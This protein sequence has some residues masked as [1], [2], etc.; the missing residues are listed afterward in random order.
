MAL[1]KQTKQFFFGQGIDTKTTPEALPIGKLT[2][3]EN[4]NFEKLGKISKRPGATAFSTT[5]LVNSIDDGTHAMTNIKSVFGR[6]KAAHIIQKNNK[7]HRVGNAAN[8]FVDEIY[9]RDEAS[10]NF[11][12]ESPCAHVYATNSDV[13]LPTLNPSI[14]QNMVASDAAGFSFAT[15]EVVYCNG[16]NFIAQFISDQTGTPFAEIDV[17]IID[18]TT[19]E[20]IFTQNLGASYTFTCAAVVVISA[21]EVLLLAGRTTNEIYGYKYTLTA[22]GMAPVTETSP[23]TFTA[24]FNSASK[25]FDC[26]WS[27]TSPRL[28]LAFKNQSAGTLTLNTYTTIPSTGAAAVTNT[29]TIADV[30]TNAITVFGGDANFARIYVAYGQ[31]LGTY[32]AIYSM[33]LGVILATSQRRNIQPYQLTGGFT[34]TDDGNGNKYILLVVN[35]NLGAPHEA[36]IYG[37]TAGAWTA[38]SATAT[39]VG[40]YLCSKVYTDSSG[41]PYLVL[42]Q[43]D[44]NVDPTYFLAYLQIVGSSCI[45]V[46]PAAKLMF[47]NA[48]L[49]AVRPGLLSAGSGSYSPVIWSGYRF[50]LTIGGRSG[51]TQF[52]CYQ[53]N[54]VTFTF[55]EP[56]KYQF[57]EIHDLAYFNGGFPAVFDGDNFF[58]ANFLLSPSQLAGV[59][60]V[61]AGGLT[62][63]TTY[64]AVAVFEYT[65]S[66]GNLHQSAPS[67]PA[68]VTMTGAQ[69]TIDW[70]G[71]YPSMTLH[72]KVNLVIYRTTG[73][74]TLFYRENTSIAGAAGAAV[75]MQSTTSDAV[76]LSNELIYTTG[77][78]LENQSLGPTKALT[79]WQNRV[80][81]LSEDKVFFSNKLDEGVPATFNALFVFNTAIAKGSPTAIAALKDKLLIFFNSSIY[82]ITGDGPNP[83]GIG[84][85]SDLETAQLGIGCLNYTDVIEAGD[86][87]YFRS[88]DGWRSISG[89]LQVSLLGLELNHYINKS[90]TIYSPLFI[91]DLH[92]IR[93]SDG[94]QTFCLDTVNQQ[95]SKRTN[96]DDKFAAY[97]NNRYIRVRNTSAG[98]TYYEDPTVFQDAG[99]N[100]QLLV[101]TG[102]ITFDNIL[103]FQR[104]YEFIILGRYWSANTLTVKLFYDY[105]PTVAETFTFDPAGKGISNYTD[106][107][108]YDN[109]SASVVSPFEFA[110]KPAQQRCEAVRIE[111]V[112]VFGSGSNQGFD[113]VGLNAVIGVNSVKAKIRD[114][115]KG[116]HSSGTAGSGL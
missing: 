50:K 93:F 3:L 13:P 115:A 85:F 2:S 4:G 71:F 114:A 16:Y 67:V 112:D 80:I 24:D 14:C 8:G 44:L 56:G 37:A 36:Y 105:N 81:A 53:A 19:N 87:V 98:P 108:V 22:A 77:N 52:K 15:S 1:L 23:I 88:T 49:I 68:S 47:G 46:K 78:V 109:D 12:Y 61:A 73:N 89:A 35:Y 21:T 99:A 43:V 34:Q 106:A 11:A 45:A 58:E 10:G 63:L 95:W 30:V 28:V 41:M 42:G 103:G 86:I 29:A 38:L 5:K 26:F 107:N 111:I 40:M 66:E 101:R 65:D 102:W 18:P 97:I 79:L 59:A 94:T 48:G 110:I 20:T 64:Q 51:V 69:N 82:Y 92:Q 9:V 72:S 33:T 96:W 100:Y 113:L 25:L 27:A 7:D 75:T 62:L 116:S 32:S 84:S 31:A 104:I 60:S 6:N 74:G 17:A 57:K 91:Y 90:T 76:L 55:D 83:I 54:L 70:S 39:V